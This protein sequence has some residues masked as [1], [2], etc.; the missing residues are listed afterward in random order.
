MHKITVV[1]EQNTIPYSTIESATNK[2]YTLDVIR[3]CTRQNRINHFFELIAIGLQ[4]WLD[5]GGGWIPM[6]W[7]TFWVNLNNWILVSPVILILIVN[8][9]LI[10]PKQLDKLIDLKINATL[11]WTL[12]IVLY[13]TAYR[14][15]LSVY[16]YL[17]RRIEYWTQCVESVF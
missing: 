2:R 8:D 16:S 6:T 9:K 7:Q 17:I 14:I 15:L 12:C 11:W 1:Q 4:F 3:S 5:C 13:S 10:N